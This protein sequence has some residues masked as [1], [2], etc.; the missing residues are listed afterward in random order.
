MK[1]FM[2]LFIN[3]QY[4][5]PLFSFPCPPLGDITITITVTSPFTCL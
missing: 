5:I 1:L 2:V 4:V 3:S